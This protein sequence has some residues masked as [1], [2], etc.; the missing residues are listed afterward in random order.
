MRTSRVKSGPRTI[1]VVERM[2]GCRLIVDD[3]AKTLGTSVVTPRS[4]VLSLRGWHACRPAN[5]DTAAR[6]AGANQAARVDAVL[7]Q[8][9]GSIGRGSGFVGGVPGGFGGGGDGGSGFGLG[10]GG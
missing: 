2:H 8:R 7:Y 3:V 1:S 9:F 5:T 4:A 6:R 10:V